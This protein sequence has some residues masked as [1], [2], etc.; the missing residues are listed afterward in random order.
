[1]LPEDHEPQ[2]EEVKEKAPD[3][4]M[5]SREEWGKNA[6]ST[7]FGITKMRPAVKPKI[8]GLKP[9]L[10]ADD[11]FNELKQWAKSLNNRPVIDLPE[12]GSAA[13]RIVM[14]DEELK[15]KAVR[16]LLSLRI[17]AAQADLE[18]MPEGTSN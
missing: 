14:A 16:E 18:K 15:T 6:A 11:T 2:L 10:V 1:M 3:Q 17:R 9:L 4:V 8:P 13:L 7:A 5:F 12:L